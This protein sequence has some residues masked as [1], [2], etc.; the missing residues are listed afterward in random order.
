[1]Y[2]ILFSSLDDVFFYKARRKNFKA[3][4]NIRVLVKNL[5]GLLLVNYFNMRV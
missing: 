4:E 5:Q 2:Y 3:L 1:M